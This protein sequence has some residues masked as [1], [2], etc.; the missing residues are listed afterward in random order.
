MDLHV[1]GGEDGQEGLQYL[2]LDALVSVG[3]AEAVADGVHDDVN[4]SLVGVLQ[5][6]TVT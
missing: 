1:L 3:A 6:G 4:L 5:T 2:Q